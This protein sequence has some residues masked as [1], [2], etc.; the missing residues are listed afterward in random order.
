MNLPA[1]KKFHLFGESSQE[2][3]FILERH[4][5]HLIE[6][7]GMTRSNVKGQILI[8][9]QRKKMYIHIS[10]YVG[11]LREYRAEN[12]QRYRCCSTEH[13]Q[14]RISFSS[15]DFFTSWRKPPTVSSRLMQRCSYTTLLFSRSNQVYPHAHRLTSVSARQSG[16][17]TA[18]SRP[19]R[20]I[21]K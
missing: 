6:H 15:W 4:R 16:Y 21:E 12:F 17:V 5:V 18:G 3:V 2:R 20:Y 1:V 19:S 9:L 7:N 13:T 10:M 14:S 8:H 11:H